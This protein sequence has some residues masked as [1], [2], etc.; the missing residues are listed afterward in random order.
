MVASSS[1]RWALVV[2]ACLSIVL[3]CRPV[4]RGGAALRGAGGSAV[5][6]RYR[7][8][9][10]PSRARSA[11]QPPGRSRIDHRYGA[12]AWSTSRGGGAAATGSTMPG[13]LRRRSLK[14]VLWAATEGAG[15]AALSFGSFAV[16]AV[17][18]EPR[19]FGVVALAGVPVYFLLMRVGH[20]F[21]DPL[22]QR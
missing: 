7:R 10:L 19:D 22:V 20:S 8:G 15:V 12:P 14:G 2:S 9:C 17:M 21:S 6:A 4:Q 13:D 11:T 5:Y 3:S 1:T 16:M 18:L